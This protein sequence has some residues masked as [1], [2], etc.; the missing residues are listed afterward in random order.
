[1]FRDQQPQAQHGVTDL[2]G[3]SLSDAA[4]NAQRIAVGG[5]H[6]FAGDLSGDL[7]RHHPRPALM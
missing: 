5:P 4:F 3:Q 7:F 2:V 6:Q 1:M